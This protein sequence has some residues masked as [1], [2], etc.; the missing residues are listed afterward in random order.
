MRTGRTETGRTKLIAAV[1]RV[2]AA[3]LALCICQGTAGL[4]G[5]PADPARILVVLNSGRAEYELTARGFLDRIADLRPGQETVQRYLP[6][7]TGQEQGFWQSVQSGKTA[8]IVTIGSSSS[9]SAFRNTAGIPLVSSVL[10]DPPGASEQTTDRPVTALLLRP[11][12]ESQLGRIRES[13]PA[14]RR[15]GLLRS[16]LGYKSGETA[17]SA[18]ALG[19]RLVDAAVESDRDIPD[20][21]R[22]IIDQ[23]DILWLPPDSRIYNREALRFIL[24]ECHSRGMPVVAFTRRIAEAGAALSL[25]FDYEDLGAQTAELAV[26]QLAGKR[27]GGLVTAAPRCLKLYI[28][29][30]VAFGLGLHIPPQILASATLV[31]RERGRP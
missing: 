2:A 30:T 31:G 20:A 23:I 14:V 3:F 29:E 17:S 15:V 11:S 4:P 12:P 27:T 13:L 9:V 26:E 7:S 5:A 24:E 6:E 18:E 22:R 16:P 21:L 10:L 25:D 8:L 19:L 28:N 1:T